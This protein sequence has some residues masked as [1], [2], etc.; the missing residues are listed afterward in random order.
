M[1]I[2]TGGHRCVLVAAKR[3]TPSLS[4]MG[5]QAVLDILQAMA[6]RIER[7]GATVCEARTA[8]ANF[9]VERAILP[10]SANFDAPRRRA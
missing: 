7:I 3:Q 5:S 1:A 9:D 6:R 8:I 4:E 2:E 10:G